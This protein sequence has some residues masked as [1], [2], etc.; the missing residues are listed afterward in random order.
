[1]IQ[2]YREKWIYIYIYMRDLVCHCDLQKI[3]SD[4]K[5]LGRETET[6]PPPAFVWTAHMHTAFF[7]LKYVWIECVNFNFDLLGSHRNPDPSKKFLTLTDATC[8]LLA[9]SAYSCLSRCTVANGVAMRLYLKDVH[10]GLRSAQNWTEN[11]K[12]A[13]IC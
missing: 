10:L 2:V 3:Q 6:T 5:I 1:M 11:I 8:Y 13:G 7:V 4:L 9:T 12:H